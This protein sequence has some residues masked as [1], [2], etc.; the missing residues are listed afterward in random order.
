MCGDEYVCFVCM[1]VCE[2]SQ[3]V[4]NLVAC[5]A[6]LRSHEPNDE[7]SGVYSRP[8]S[9]S[10]GSWRPPTLAVGIL[11]TELRTTTYGQ[12]IYA[13]LYALFGLVQAN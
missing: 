8:K 9:I 12:R 2:C 10:L 6:D 13:A 4:M 5:T 3:S 7:F 11:T 1:Y